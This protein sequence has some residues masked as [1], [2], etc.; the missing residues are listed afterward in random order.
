M[1]HKYKHNFDEEEWGR[2]SETNDP[3]E[4][5]KGRK[6]SPKEASKQ[7]MSTKTTDTKA[8]TK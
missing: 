5:V 7:Q 8:S 1:I 2:I 3:Y 6:D 4:P